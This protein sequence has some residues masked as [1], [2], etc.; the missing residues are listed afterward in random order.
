MGKE[1]P[2]NRVANNYLLS[3]VTSGDVRI[4]A[5][6]T[7]SYANDGSLDI[8]AKRPLNRMS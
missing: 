6:A 3:A 2:E 4:G 1:L 7:E 5:L 8:K